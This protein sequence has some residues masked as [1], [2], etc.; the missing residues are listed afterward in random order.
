MD[1]SIDYSPKAIMAAMQE[2]YENV[3]NNPQL[4]DLKT[5]LTTAMILGS[6]ATPQMAAAEGTLPEGSVTYT[7]FME[8]ITSHNIERV[9]IAADGRTAEFLNTRVRG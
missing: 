5:Q 2:F 8:G 6:M 3:L 4:K 7:K 9:R 1:K